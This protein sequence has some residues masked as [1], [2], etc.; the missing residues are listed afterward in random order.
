MNARCLRRGGLTPACGSALSVMSRT[1]ENRSRKCDS[2]AK[3]KKRPWLSQ[4]VEQEKTKP[5]A[6]H[7]LHPTQ[8][9]Y[10]LAKS[11]M[12]LLFRPALHD[13]KL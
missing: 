10:S 4:V 9:T 12:E 8:V 13:A 6:M 7:P 5:C 11:A 3:I 2:S 1:L